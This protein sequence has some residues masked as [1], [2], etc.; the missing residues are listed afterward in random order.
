MLMMKMLF[1]F[2]GDT[3]DGWQFKVRGGIEASYSS[4]LNAENHDDADCD[5]T[6]DH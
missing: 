3:D 4:D 6:V 5:L 1:K 2:S